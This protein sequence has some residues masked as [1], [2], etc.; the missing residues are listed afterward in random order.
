MKLPLKAHD[1]DCSKECG[2]FTRDQFVCDPVNGPEIVEP[3]RTMWANMAKP[4][5]MMRLGH[6]LFRTCTT[7]DCFR[8]GHCFHVQNFEDYGWPQ[9][10]G[11]FHGH[12]NGFCPENCPMARDENGDWRRGIFWDYESGAPTR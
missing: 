8:D 4:G 6:C 2:C 10:I 11:T 1:G 3:P 9:R 7:C 5:E 12:L